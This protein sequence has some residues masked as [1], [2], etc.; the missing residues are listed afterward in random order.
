MGCLLRW[1]SAGKGW[2][3]GGCGAKV[4]VGRWWWEDDGEYVGP[5]LR[6]PLQPRDLLDLKLLLVESKLIQDLLVRSLDLLLTIPLLI[7]WNVVVG[8]SSMVC[9]V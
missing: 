2:R 1:C 7:L 4:V 3:L 5:D 6:F 9:Q 8:V